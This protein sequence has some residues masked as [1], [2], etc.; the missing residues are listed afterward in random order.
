MNS[1]AVNGRLKGWEGDKA[2]TSE[3]KRLYKGEF[4]GVRPEEGT[5]TRWGVM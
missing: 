5:A 1:V 3:R 2:D 4:I